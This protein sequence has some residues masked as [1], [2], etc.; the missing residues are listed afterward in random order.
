MLK[1]FWLKERDSN[2]E[3]NSPEKDKKKHRHYSSLVPRR[4]FNLL[5]I[6]KDSRTGL[7]KIS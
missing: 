1:M 4:G 2:Y 5:I 7:V 3:K 6:I